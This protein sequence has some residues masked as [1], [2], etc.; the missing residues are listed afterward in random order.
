M[1]NIVVTATANQFPLTTPHNPFMLTDQYCLVS[2][3]QDGTQ[4]WDISNPNAPFLAGYFDT[5]PVSGGNNNT[6]PGGVNYNGQWG[7]YPWF[8]SKSVFALDRH[9]GIF[10]MNTHL[11]SNP[12]INIIGNSINIPDGSVSTA[13]TNNTNFGSVIITASA[14]N[15]FIVQNT[16]LASLNVSSI[17]ITGADASVFS[18]VGP[19]TPF[20]VTPSGAQILGIQ[21]A[22]LTVGTKT[23]L[24]HLFNNDY[25]EG[26][27]DFVV[28]GDAALNVGINEQIATNFNLVV[29]PNPASD[30]LIVKYND[31][32]LKTQH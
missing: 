14:T 11:Y 18:I 20:T 12:E 28:S 26:S 16:G 8:P 2:A 27:Y 15:N 7:L 1:S 5:Y 29:Y 23:A 21:F 24:V 22:P 32:K 13:T 6:W 17:T 4:L 9:N 31:L 3:Y 19:S 10:V 25:N 30:H